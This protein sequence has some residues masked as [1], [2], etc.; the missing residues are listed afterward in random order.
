MFREF[1]D[2]KLLTRNFFLSLSWNFI[3]EF[4]VCSLKFHK[5]SQKLFR[6]LFV[7]NVLEYGELLYMKQRTKAFN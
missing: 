5:F 2:V 4:A 7:K 3:R 1:F 6:E